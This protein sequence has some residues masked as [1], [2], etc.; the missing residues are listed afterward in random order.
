LWPER[1]RKSEKKK[2]EKFEKETL[3]RKRFLYQ[4]EN[5]KFFDLVCGVDSFFCVVALSTM[6]FVLFVVVPS[7]QQ[8]EK[9]NLL[10]FGS[11][12]F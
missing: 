8:T 2:E 11:T 12:S 5:R 6:M 9:K 1:K 7:E 3:L 10:L 4:V